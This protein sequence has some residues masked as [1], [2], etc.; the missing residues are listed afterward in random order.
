MST[1][2]SNPNKIILF[3]NGAYEIKHSTVNSISFNKFQNAKFFEK[4]SSSSLT[5]SAPFFIKDIKKNFPLENISNLSRNYLRPLSRGLLNDIDLQLDIW[6]KIFNIYYSMEH[7]DET[8][9]E[10]CLIFTHTPFAPDEIIEGF[11]EIIFEYFNFD[12]C[13]KTIPHVFTSIYNKNIHNNNNIVQLIVD[14]GFSSTTIVPTFENFPIFNAIK[15]VEIGGKLLTNFL[16]ESLINITDI[17]IRKEFYLINLMKEENCF[18]SKNFLKDMNLSK[19]P[20]N[21]N[22]INIIEN[23]I[24]T[25]S[26]FT[27]R[28]ILP[29][30]RKNIEKNNKK[31]DKF[32][33]LINNLRFVV[34]EII[35]NPNMIGIEEGGIQ[36]GIIQSINE[37]HEDYKNLLFQNIICNGGNSKFDNFKER[38]SFELNNCIDHDFVKNIKVDCVGKNDENVV[39]GMKIFGKN[40]DFLKDVAITK[41]EYDD[42]GF[43]IVW[44]TCY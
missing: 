16:K 17:D 19:I 40:I 37:C 38:L 1:W 28:F 33:I 21:N 3:D 15:R 26:I 44:K 22:N 13:F 32:S 8:F 42:I 43:N 35:F 27:K 29:E 12:A 10:N 9:K 25:N 14:S 2:H 36:E 24:I 23:N 18:I 30:F 34:P 7:G 41:K 20:I 11:F 31:I 39:E 4:T 6:E 5:S